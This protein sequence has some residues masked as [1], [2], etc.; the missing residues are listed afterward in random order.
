MRGVW[1]NSMRSIRPLL[2]LGVLMAGCVR[3]GTQY[4]PVILP[5]GAPT[6]QAILAELAENEAALHTFKATGKFVLQSP[7]LE[8]TQLLRESAIFF[9]S[10]ASLHVVGRKMATN[11]V[12]LTCVG[13]AFLVVFPTEKEYYY[14]PEG[15]RVEG[16]DA[17]A[18]VREMFQ[19]EPW[20][21]LAPRHVRITGFDPQ[22]QQATLEIYSGRRRNRLR[23]RLTLQGVPWVVIRNERFDREGQLVA[24]TTK[25]EYHEQNGVRFPAQL[26]ST[27]P[28]V[29]AYMR[30]TMRRV[31][32][33]EELDQGD[34]AMTKRVEALGR[35]GYQAIEQY[36]AEASGS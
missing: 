25:A 7:E 8:A 11:V 34:F 36:H 13:D 28:H 3:L 27:F 18:I 26:E 10:P 21:E 5:P 4:Q 29:E 9:Q 6:A 19:P 17:S 12:E 35:K 31:W 23:R 14:R 2:L 15:E 22:Q 1:A 24:V 33:N 20:A 32:V 16:Q 30:F